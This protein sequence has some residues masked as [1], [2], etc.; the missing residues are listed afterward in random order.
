MRQRELAVRATLGATVGR[1][2]RQLLTESVLL[3][4]AA[5]AV[6]LLLAVWGVRLLKVL[7]P[8][9]IPRLD[10]AGLN[11]Q[12]LGFALA[13]ALAVTLLFGLMPAWH[14]ARRNFDVG[15]A[16][17]ARG[18]T[19]TPALRQL[20]SALI[21][22]E[23]A[24]AVTLANSA[25][26]LVRS[27]AA[28]QAVDPGFQPDRVLTLRINTPLIASPD[29]LITLHDSILQR[30]ANVTGVEA[31]GT[32]DDLIESGMPAVSGLRMI[33]GRE[34]ERR[35]DWTPLKWNTVSGAYFQAMG[36]PLL[37]GRFFNDQDTSA[38]PWVALID[39]AVAHRYW[40]NDDPIGKHFKGQDRRGAND[41]WITVVGVV[42][43]ARRSGLEKPPVPHI[44]LSYKQ[45]GV[46]NR[47]DLVARTRVQPQLVANSLRQ[48]VRSV[49]QSSILSGVSTLEEIFSGQLAPRRF[50]TLLLV[51]FSVLALLLAG[52]G[53]YSVM[54]QSVAQRTSEIGVRMAL[55]AC[56][57]A[58]LQGIVKEGLRLAGYGV[59]LGLF[60][61]LVLA[62]LLRGLLFGIAPNDPISF[63]MAIALLMAIAAVG[64]Y[65]PARRASR[66]D[67][68]VALRHE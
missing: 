31:A 28:V 11:L 16:L 38:S 60:G 64:C 53:I 8:A 20:R 7:A 34:P 62:R 6:A 27:L 54:H 15:R 30:A 67:P 5:T 14:I 32:I 63:V 42:G 40:G 25:L 68:I 13:L 48:A 4:I 45:A 52:I 66:V 23:F 29:R 49:E 22:A 41:D 3:A 24:L 17:N 65:V 46:S 12:L 57:A 26:L 35:E 2:V 58:V 44:Y 21:L 59:L 51:T 43:T 1:L 9:T 19:I 10:E 47:V 37:R 39:D 56:P 36:L 55:G 18:T 50:Q 61:A 33:E